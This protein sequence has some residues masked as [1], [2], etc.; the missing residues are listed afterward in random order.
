MPTNPIPRTVDEYIA[1]FAPAVQTV[2]TKIRRTDQA[3]APESEETI[4]YQMPAFKQNRTLVDS[5]RSYRRLHHHQIKDGKH[6]GESGPTKVKPPA[7]VSEVRWRQRRA[8]LRRARR[9]IPHQHL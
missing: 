2:L 8:L 9:Q 4:S 3:A 6:S 5:R 7:I 1:G